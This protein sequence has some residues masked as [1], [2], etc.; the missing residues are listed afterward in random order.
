MDV[1]R[2]RIKIVGK[3][4]YGSN[5][6]DRV[7]R[8]ERWVYLVGVRDGVFYTF[9]FSFRINLSIGVYFRDDIKRGVDWSL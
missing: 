7:S 8:M 2:L 1:I 9:F 4:L 6:M 5:S 3:F